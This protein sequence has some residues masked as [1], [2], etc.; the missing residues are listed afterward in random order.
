MLLFVDAAVRGEN[1]S[2]TLILASR[3]LETYEQLH[4]DEEIVRLEL[5]SMDLKPLTPADLAEIDELHEKGEL[6]APRFA[7][8]RQLASAD[9][10]VIA[11]PFWNLSFPAVFYLWLEAVSV[12]DI[13]FGFWEN[14]LHGLCRSEKLMYIATRG[15]D[16]S[17][18]DADMETAIPQLRA[19]SK[20]YGLGELHTVIAEGIDLDGYDADAIMQKALEDAE[21][22][23]RSF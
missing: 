18:E 23:A 10:V 5:S 20:M 12:S 19:Y 21:F 1:V 3:F 9:R 11:A 15:G 17:S 7:L 8:A 13:T 14:R 22:A 6:D 4:P 16:Y 2:R